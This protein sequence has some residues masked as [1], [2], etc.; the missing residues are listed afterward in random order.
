MSGGYN[1]EEALKTAIMT[2]KAAMDFYKFGALKMTDEHA[3]HTFAILAADEK[4]HARMF[5]DV[6]PG[7]DLPPFAELMAAAPDTE[8]PWWK[9]LQH[10]LLS[11]FDERR[12][13]E[14]AIDQEDALEKSLRA[15]AAMISDP[16]IREIYLA[17]ADST[18]GHSRLVSED[19]KAF[20]G[21][22][23]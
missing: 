4:Q 21:Q 22:S 7:S 18:H 2:E 3:C 9:S 12:A 10:I 16:K 20:F 5:Y 19:L 15:T 6:Y 11:N 14:L 1:V 8:S 23:R 17:N 13:L